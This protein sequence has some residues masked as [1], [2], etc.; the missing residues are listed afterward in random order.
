LSFSV[1]TATDPT[2]AEQH[3]LS[4]ATA[5]SSHDGIQYDVVS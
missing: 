1:R 5:P 2:P 4:P 3:A